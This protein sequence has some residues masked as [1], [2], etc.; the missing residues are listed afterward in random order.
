MG[1]IQIRDGLDSSYSDVYTPEAMAALT[2]LTRFNHDQ[3]TVMRER[4]A[5]R[6]ER[7]RKGER[8]AFLDADAGIPRT[9]IVVG[10]ARAGDFVGADIPADLQR[11][12]IQGTGP[13]AKP[14]APLER[15]IRNAAYALLSGADGWM[16]DGEDA[17]GQIL[18]LSLDN[19][20][21]LKLAI[22]RDLLFLRAAE[23][24]A[25]E[26]N[27]WAQGFFGRAIVEDWERQLDFTTVIF[28]ARG[29]HL[30]DR[31]IRDGDGVALSASIVDMVLYVVNNFQQLR[32]SDSSIVLYLPK[33]QFAE[34][35][36]LWDQMIAA[37]EAHL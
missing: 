11:Q 12:W 21:N 30:D 3:K 22:A 17:L 8:L 26:M 34:E 14:N 4:M 15:S 37:L 25:G 7:M 16:F 9:G 35:A 20:R 2:A 13:A 28:R 36:A 23:Q 24:V 29:L 32:Q 19:Q 6:T 33:I 31:H 27:Q 10:R 1:S 5:R 18:S